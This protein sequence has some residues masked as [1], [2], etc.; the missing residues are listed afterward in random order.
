MPLNPTT[1]IRD[2]LIAKHDQY[3]HPSFILND[4]IQVPHSFSSREDIEIAAFLTATIAWGNRAS[5]IK[6]ANSLMDRMDREPFEFVRSADSIDMDRLDS[7]VHRTFNSNDVSLF[8]RALREVYKEHGGLEQVFTQGS[9]A[10]G[11]FGSLVNFRRVFV[12]CGLKGRTLKHV[13]DVEKGSAAKRLNLFLMWMVR[14]D[15]RGVHFGLWNGISP[16]QLMIPLDTHVGRVARSLGLLKRKT[17]DWQA[18]EE[19]TSVL[20]KID[21]DDPCKFDFSLF[22]L[23][24]FDHF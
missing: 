6:S 23:G 2:L 20:R 19:L 4:P 17:N 22:G 16:A 1:E 15:N 13:S 8:V 11:A 9:R 10:G 3:N 5:I 18:V 21:P 14:K 12:L 24:L 7:F